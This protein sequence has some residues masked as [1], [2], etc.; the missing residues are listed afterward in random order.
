MAV[1]GQHLQDVKIKDNFAKLIEALYAADRAARE[2]E[3]QTRAHIQAQ[4]AAK[5]RKDNEQCL[6]LLAEKARRERYDLYCNP[7]TV[8]LQ[9]SARRREQGSSKSE[10]SADYLSSEDEDLPKRCSR[11]RRTPSRT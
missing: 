7:L 1:K 5:E 9:G 8:R 3:V 10:E 6:K 2:A 4:L 11:T